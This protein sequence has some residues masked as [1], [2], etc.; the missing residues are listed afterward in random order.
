MLVLKWS[1]T[2]EEVVKSGEK[3]IIRIW[4]DAKLRENENKKAI[5]ILND[6]MRSHWIKSRIYRCPDGNKGSD[7]GL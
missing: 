5:Q 4:K 3:D 2:P 6:A 1:L 7:R